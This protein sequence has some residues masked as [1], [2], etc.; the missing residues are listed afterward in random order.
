M[1]AASS[2]GPNNLLLLAVLGIG[3]YYLMTRR[4]VA[5]P[6]YQNPQAN[7]T[8]QN[9]SLMGAGLGALG[10]LFRGSGG[11]STVP[12]LGTYDGRAAQPWDVTPQG[13]DGPRYNNP[14]A[15]V[16]GGNDGLP[17]NP[18]FSSAYDF[19]NEYWY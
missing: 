7:R 14:S 4:A 15:Y 13:A 9:A 18:P 10:N 5:Q 12:Y 17:I 1:S 6:M 8:A 11:G 19:S 16:A 2:P 3:A